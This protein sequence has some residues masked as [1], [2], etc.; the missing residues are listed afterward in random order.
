M[1]SGAAQ[2]T[3]G[4]VRV[5][6]NKCYLLEF[7]WDPQGQWRLADNPADLLLNTTQGQNIFERIPPSQASR[8][9]GLWI[10][11]DRSSYEHTN[12][13]KSITT[14]CPDRVRS[15]HKRKADT[16]YYFQSTVKNTL[17]YS[18]VKTTMTKNQCH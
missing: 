12:Q 14:A 11:P 3:G 13:I 2:T 4:Q 6:K 15:G 9:L 7:R 1:F 17:E 10:D 18:L 8:I 16:W 5:S